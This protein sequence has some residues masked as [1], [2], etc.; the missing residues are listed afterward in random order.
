MNLFELDKFGFWYM[1][2]MLSI[3]GACFGSFLNVVI[4]RAFT[5]ESIVLPPS[6]CPK[7]H[8]K[9]KWY[10]NIP[11]LSYLFLRGKCGFCKEPI[12]IQY[13]LVE[14]A[15]W[16][17]FLGVFLKFGLNWNSIFLASASAMCLV[18]AVTDIKEQ[19]IFDTHAYI[20]AG[21]GLVYNFFDIAKSGLGAYNLTFFAHS[22]S[23]NKSFVYAILGLIAGALAMELLALVGRVL[24][25]KRAFGEGDSFIL[26]ALGAVFGIK[27]VLP[28][29]LIGCVVQVVIIFPM[30][31]KKL[32]ET[33]EYKLLCGLGAFIISVAGFKILESIKLLDNL[34]I[35]AIAF[36]VMGAC[37]LYTCKKLI[38]STKKGESLTYVPFGPP[39][40][41]AAITLMFIA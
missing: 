34:W 31:V 12:S 35:F 17:L 8:N 6:K 14:T 19:V 36:F 30:F 23:I 15:Y 27:S 39:L 5:G 25:G 24:V 16:L 3:L 33:K 22:F 28:I 26:G 29:L 1:V 21:I 20:L 13:P 37:A 10:H 4:L 41:I 40:V 9:L 11:I 32:F 2:C 7:C 18:L 38:E